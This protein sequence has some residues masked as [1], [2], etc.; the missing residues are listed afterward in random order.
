MDAS[1]G[2]GEGHRGGEADSVRAAGDGAEATLESEGGRRIEITHDGLVL[3]PSS[4]LSFSDFFVLPVVPPMRAA[5][6][7]AFRRAMADRPD[8]DQ[9]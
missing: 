5:S 1:T 8:G 2:P 4:S 3:S 9:W 6:P 7:A